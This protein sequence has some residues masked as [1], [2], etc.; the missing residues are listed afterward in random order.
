MSESPSEVRNGIGR[1]GNDG[2]YI[3]YQLLLTRTYI[4][5]VNTRLTCDK[6]CPEVRGPKSGGL[7]YRFQHSRNR[8]VTAVLGR[9]SPRRLRL[10]YNQFRH[11]PLSDIVNPFPPLPSPLFIR[12]RIRLFLHWLKSKTPRFAASASSKQKNYTTF[13]AKGYLQQ[14]RE[15]IDCN[16]SAF[17]A[18]YVTVAPNISPHH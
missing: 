12:N 8:Y 6:S 5:Y 7:Q 18:R 9:Y 13:A 17:L 16:A 15:G 3:R 4:Y 2:L 14:R 11:Y 1:R 10:I